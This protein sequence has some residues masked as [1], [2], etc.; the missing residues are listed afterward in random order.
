MEIFVNLFPRLI[1]HFYYLYFREHINTYNH[2]H[3]ITYDQSNR[4]TFR[5]K[6][7][8]NINFESNNIR[9]RMRQN[10]KFYVRICSFSNM[11]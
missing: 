2:L 10:I 9:K 1:T 3:D 8:Y 6:I 11:M 4:Q 5:H 7:L